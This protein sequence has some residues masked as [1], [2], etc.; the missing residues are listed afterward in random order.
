MSEINFPSV[1]TKFDTILQRGLCSG[2][3]KPDGQMCIEAAICAALDLPHGDNPSCV[4][5]A[6]R[7]FKIALNDSLW[8]SPQAR[9]K[10]LRDLGIAQIGS[11]GVVDGKE[12]CSLLRKYTIQRLIPDLFRRCPI[13]VEPHRTNILEAA[14]VCEK[15]GGAA[16][17]AGA[18]WVAGAAGAAPEPDYFLLLCA[19]IALDV[20][21]ELKSPGVVWLD[22]TS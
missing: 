11:K 1:I 14:K 10:G 17:A 8:S 15:T 3:G 13:K 20:L 16:E 7:S 6:V 18:A 2:L 19:S 9:A 4:E 21:R 5:P 12:F 22:K